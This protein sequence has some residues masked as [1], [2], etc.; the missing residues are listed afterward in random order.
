MARQLE[1]A[2]TRPKP[3]NQP[4]N[5]PLA[6]QPPPPPVALKPAAGAPS[7]PAT[8][9]SVTASPGEGPGAPKSYNPAASVAAAAATV[10]GIGSLFRSSSSA[11]PAGA[12]PPAPSRPS[13]PQPLGVSTGRKDDSAG[14]EAAGAKDINGRSSGAETDAAPS[15]GVGVDTP[16]LSPG[17]ES[18]PVKEFEPSD[19]GPPPAERLSE[20]T[21]A[22]GEQ[23]Q[24]QAKLDPAATKPF[25][26]PVSEEGTSLERLS[27]DE[28]FRETASH[29]AASG[30]SA[31]AGSAS[32]P[33]GQ[34]EARS[35]DAAPEEERPKPA[36][37]AIDPFSV[38]EIEAEFAR[39]LG[40]TVEKDPKSS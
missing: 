6:Q 3:T 22:E 16:I 14:S 17:A 19:F 30:E 23:A 9:A 1:T 36:P 34:D 7:T 32:P 13:P 12:T 37:A 18:A 33:A 5:Q 15:Q 35:T 27:E 2:L 10:A 25:D 28:P 21:P 39:L 8:S 24:R 40:R 11:A 29:E 38:D 4:T 20:P 26:A 31:A